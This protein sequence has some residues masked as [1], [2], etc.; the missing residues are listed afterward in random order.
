MIW[1]RRLPIEGPHSA[2]LARSGGSSNR[3][4][5]AHDGEMPQPLSEN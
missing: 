3:K 2:A 1:I 4:I 5:P